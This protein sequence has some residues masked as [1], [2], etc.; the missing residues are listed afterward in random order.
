MTV[1]CWWCLI[2]TNYWAF[3]LQK[4][5]L[6]CKDNSP[7]PSWSRHQVHSSSTL[8]CSP[9][10]LVSYSHQCLVVLPC[11]PVAPCWCHG[12]LHLYSQSSLLATTLPFIGIGF[13]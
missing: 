7:V 9:E 12:S 3:V 6:E 4:S 10:H 5:L 11:L 2:A 8:E 13:D 1:D